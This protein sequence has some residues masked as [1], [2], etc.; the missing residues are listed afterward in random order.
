MPYLIFDLADGDVRRCLHFSDKLDF[1]WRFMSLHY[2]AVGLNQLHAIEVSYQDLK[3]S[4]ILVFNTESKIGDLGRSLCRSLEGPHSNLEFPGDLNYA[5]PEIMYRYYGPDWFK[6]SF[7]CDCYLLGSMV[8]FYFAGISMSALL[9]K[10]IPSNF[11]WHVWNG[12]FDEIKPYLV[13]AFAR[14]LIEFEQS[15][16]DDFFRT[17]LVWLAE[18][19]CYPFPENRGHPKNISGQV[20]QYS[21]ERFIS[22]FDL[23]HKKALYRLRH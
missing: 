4:N 11:R 9:V 10:N 1:A 7:A 23:L 20:T 13:D 14:A 2:I 12:P 21:M 18:R 17:D 8:L 19:L 5:P 22:K 3:P 16:A 15:I 6:R